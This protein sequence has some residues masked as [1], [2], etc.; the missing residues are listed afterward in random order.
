[1]ETIL[2]EKRPASATTQKRK[3]SMKAKSSRF[4]SLVA[5]YYPAVYSFASRLTD[6]PREA[7]ALTRNAFRSTQRQLCSLRDQTAVA[8]ILIL[9]VIRAGLAAG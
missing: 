4:D 3:P 6:D 7:I 1:M 9:A 8:T 5:R 2:T